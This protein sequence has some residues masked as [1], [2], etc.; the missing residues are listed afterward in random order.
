MVTHVTLKTKLEKSWNSRAVTLKDNDS[1]DTKRKF[2]STPVALSLLLG[3]LW[4][5]GAGM[6]GNEWH[7]APPV[8]PDRY[9]ATIHTYDRSHEG[10]GPAA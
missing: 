8:G 7:T 9:A 1:S 4:L 2:H 5:L 3:F 6:D 10:V